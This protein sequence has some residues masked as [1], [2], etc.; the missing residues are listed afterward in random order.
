MK[1]TENETV[2]DIDNFEGRIKFIVAVE[3]LIRVLKIQNLL[4]F[5]HRIDEY[6]Y[7]DDSNIQTLGSNI[8]FIPCNFEKYFDKENL[9]II[10]EG[11]TKISF[12]SKIKV[13]Y[14]QS[15]VD[16]DYGNGGGGYLYEM[17]NIEDF[18][19]LMKSIKEYY[20]KWKKEHAVLLDMFS[21]NDFREHDSSDY[22]ELINLMTRL[23]KHFEGEL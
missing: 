21:M 19:A 16:T 22:F 9:E 13:K 15:V 4:S 5:Y 12:Y 14:I 10:I 6:F 2:N 3:N 20:E 18:D 11:K 17:Y 23:F 7:V 8:D 1:I